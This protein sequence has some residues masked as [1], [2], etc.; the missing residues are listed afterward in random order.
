[1]Y[2]DHLENGGLR[3]FYALVPGDDWYYVDDTTISVDCQPGGYDPSKGFWRLVYSSSAAENTFVSFDVATYA[4]AGLCI[5]GTDG[6]VYR[7]DVSGGTGPGTAGTA[8]FTQI[9][10]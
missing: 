3:N 5:K 10:E 1:M 9:S 7:I 2:C 6:K 8:T 4:T